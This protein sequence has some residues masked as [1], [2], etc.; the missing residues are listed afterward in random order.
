[1]IH[2]PEPHILL[3]RRPLKADSRKIIAEQ[4]EKEE[5]HMKARAKAL[6]N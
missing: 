4:K 5:L 3:F 1:M 2:K 6:K